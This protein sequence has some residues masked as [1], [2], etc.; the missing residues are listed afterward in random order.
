MVKPAIVIGFDSQGRGRYREVINQDN[1]ETYF[2][3]QHKSF[4]YYL[5]ASKNYLFMG[6]L[7]CAHWIK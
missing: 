7:G 2:R 5:V 1:F 3:Y 6:N 4:G